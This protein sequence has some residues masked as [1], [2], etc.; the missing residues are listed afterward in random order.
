MGIRQECNNK[1]STDLAL[2][3]KNDSIFNRRER[4]ARTVKRPVKQ[5]KRSCLGVL[6]FQHVLDCR[7]TESQGSEAVLKNQYWNHKSKEL[8][9]HHGE[10][11]LRLSCIMKTPCQ[12]IVN[13]LSLYTIIFL[14]CAA[15]SPIPTS[16]MILPDWQSIVPDSGAPLRHLFGPDGSS[17]SLRSADGVYADI[18]PARVPGDI[19]TD[20]MRARIIN[21]PYFDQNFLT[22]RRIWMGPLISNETTAT[23]QLEQR[24]RTWIYTTEFF[25]PDDENTIKVLV[26]EG[27]KMGATLA[28][29]GVPLAN[30]TNQFRRYL[31]PLPA[32][33]LEKGKHFCD[34]R[35]HNL[36]VT[37]DPSI[38]TDGRFMACSGGWDWAPYSRAG[39]ERGSRVFTFGITQPLYIATIDAVTITD[40][41]AKIYYLGPY[42]RQPLLD[43]PAGDFLVRVQVHL[44]CLVNSTAQQFIRARSQFSDEIVRLPLPR[45]EGGSDHVLL[46]N[47]TVAKDDIDLWWPNGLGRQPLYNLDIAIENPDSVFTQGW[48]RKRVGFRTVALVTVNDTDDAVVNDAIENKREGSGSH[49]MYFRINGAVVWS[50]GANVVPMDQLE[51]RLTDEAH[52]LAVQSAAAANMNMLRVWGGGAVL[53]KSFYDACDEF[54]ILVYHDLMFVGEQNHGA[55]RSESVRNEII[56]IIHKL[57]AHPSIVV[58]SGC[59]ECT[60]GG[61]N[62]DIYVTF[63]M[64]IVASEDDT[65]AVWP[66]SPSAFGWKTGVGMIDGRPNGNPLQ[67]QNDTGSTLEAHGPYQRG[68]SASHPGVNSMLTPNTYETHIPPQF[69]EQDTGPMFRNI[70]VSE[71]GASVSSSFES[72]SALLPE[73]AWSIH[74]GGPPDDCEQLIGDVNVC[75]GTNAMAERNYPCDNRIEAFFGGVSLENVGAPFFQQHLYECMIA[76]ALWMKGQ[77]EIM[78]SSNSF[79]TLVW[80]LNEVWPTGGW[81]AIEYGPRRGLQGQIVGGR[82]KPLMHLLQ[83]SLFRDVFAAC[84]KDDR[85]YVRNDSS[86]QVEVSIWLEAWNLN[87]LNATRAN[88]HV[89][90]LKQGCHSTKRFTLSPGFIDSTDV[91][92]IRIEDRRTGDLLMGSTALLQVPPR[93]LTRLSDQVNITVQVEELRSGG[94][95]LRLSADRLALYVLVSTQAEGRF[96]DNT[97]HLRPHEQKVITFEPLTAKDK[98]DRYLLERTLRLEHLGSYAPITPQPTMMGGSSRIN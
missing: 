22:E 10:D 35:H 18:C 77:I 66:S 89:M 44:R 13:I 92:L 93:L 81:G 30:V 80:Q 24:T 20:L 79:G 16:E 41:I 53:P 48:M 61:G 1:H 85:C 26:V 68:Y 37:F 42:P 33:A 56:H 8:L 6:F 9:R 63:V 55:V 88:N 76:Q 74:G 11:N 39:D 7:Q 67:V 27:I 96:S 15:G 2:N 91:V 62:M 21:D 69:H 31:V 72:L 14:S 32:E 83:M 65:R 43:G 19:L 87:E 38:G 58:W 51:G 45:L 97:F 36:T 75:N 28:L 46:L 17:W 23:P 57:S 60:Y 40:V 73:S 64:R 47:M 25:L 90:L 84:G 52:R 86:R 94:A 82:W 49:G 59:N 4:V 98:V 54:G 29:N 5:K 3:V 78:R 50:R 71:F 70:F 95:T 12:D 34:A